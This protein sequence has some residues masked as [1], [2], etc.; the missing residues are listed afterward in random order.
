MKGHQE[1][2]FSE[3]GAPP[4]WLRLLLLGVPLGGVVLA[5]F[6][7]GADGA[8]GAAVAASAVLVFGVVPL[9]LGQV[10]YG[11]VVVAD[12]RLHVGRRS[13]PVRGLDLDTVS[14][15]AGAEVFAVFGRDRLVTTPL[16]RRHT[17][18]VS[19]REGTRP[20]R[21]VVRTDRRE[22]L[23]AALGARRTS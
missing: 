18:A 10:L 1:V 13:T 23:L 19:G 20:I 17:L 14:F 11:G 8:A 2:L 22:E 21:V 7:G 5:W 6:A 15:E 16:W 12:G 9:E 4:P 3:S